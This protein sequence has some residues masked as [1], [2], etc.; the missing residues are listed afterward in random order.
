MDRICEKQCRRTPESPLS[1]PAPTQTV[2]LSVSRHWTGRQASRA[3]LRSFPVF[4]AASHPLRPLFL[5][6]RDWQQWL[7]PTV[8]W[9]RVSHSRVGLDP[10]SKVLVSVKETSALW[11]SSSLR[12]GRR[13]HLC[14]VWTEIKVFIAPLPAGKPLSSEASP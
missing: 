14:L 1:C 4:R 5:P 3:L 7:A 13:Q 11:R 10:W 6:S 8:G 12:G 9:D 2:Q